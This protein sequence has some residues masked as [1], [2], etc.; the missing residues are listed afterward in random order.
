MQAIAG[1]LITALC[2]SSTGCSNIKNTPGAQCPPNGYC[3]RVDFGA[4]AVTVCVSSSAELA[5][6][7]NDAAA[8]R[9]YKAANP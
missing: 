1:L 2:L 3:D 8:L 4:G 5:Q 6:L 9:K 7:K